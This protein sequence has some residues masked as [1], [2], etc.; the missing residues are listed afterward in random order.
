MLSEEGEQQGQL[1]SVHLRACI[2]LIHFILD[3]LLSQKFYLGSPTRSAAIMETA[4][5]L[6]RQEHTGWQ[7]GGRH[8][9]GPS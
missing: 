4:S 6:C 9:D 8:A 1:T 5:P 3:A 7:P 2:Y